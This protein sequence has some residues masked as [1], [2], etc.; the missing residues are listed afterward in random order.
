VNEP[1]SAEGVENGGAFQS[2]PAGNRKEALRITF[3]LTA[4]LYKE[5]PLQGQMV[6][7]IWNVRGDSWNVSLC[8]DNVHAFRNVGRADAVA[9]KTIEGPLPRLLEYART[10]VRSCVV[11]LAN[12]NRKIGKIRKE[13]NP[14]SS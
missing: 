10:A 3:R 2:R 4:A 12:L 13:E 1:E 6:D 14:R 11:I 9:G 8:N 7:V 5:R